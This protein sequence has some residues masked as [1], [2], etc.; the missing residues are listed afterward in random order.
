MANNVT[1]EFELYEPMRA[2]LQQYLENKYKGAKVTTIDSHARTLD[3]YLE[4]FGIIDHY[5][6]SVGLDIQ[7]DVLGIIINKGKPNIAFIEAKKTQLNLHDLGQLWAYC[8]LCEPIEA[9]LLSSAGLGSLN[10]VLN[11]LNRQDLLDFGS[12]KTIKKMQVGK[13][14][15]NAKS[16]DYKTL[17]PKM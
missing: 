7:I 8:K 13:W 1:K 2:W 6:Q 10:K 12:G 4:Q 3:T 9:F 16:I 5:P 11:N 14:D 17:I 15:V